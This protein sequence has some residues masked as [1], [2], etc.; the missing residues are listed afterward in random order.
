[1]RWRVQKRRL[2]K[3]GIRRI[4]GAEEKETQGIWIEGKRIGDITFT[5]DT[6]WFD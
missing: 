2:K 4:G 5:R 1:M 3:T 6:L